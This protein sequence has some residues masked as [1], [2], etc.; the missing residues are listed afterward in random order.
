MHNFS[1]YAPTKV[2]FGRG[3][4]LQAGAVAKSFGAKKA[5]VHYGGGSAVR[6]GLLDRVKS[7][8]AEAGIGFVVLGG[9]VPNPQLS[10]VR[11]GIALCI[12]SGVDFVLAVGGGSVIDSAKAI[13]CGAAEPELDVWELF[14]KKRRARKTLPVG[15]VLTIAATGSEMSNSS[16][17]TNDIGEKRSY[18]DD[19]IRAK[20]A[21]MNPELTETLP[22][23]QT[24]AGCSDILL[25]T[26]ER[27]FNVGGTCELTDAIAAA[28]IKTVMKHAKIL[29]TDPTN[30]ESRAEVMWAGSLSHNDLTG[31]GG[32][33]RGDW[34]CHKL[35]HELSG[36]FGVTH[37]AGLT[38]LW[39]TW[40]RY[41]YAEC[42]DRFVKFALDV[43]GVEAGADDDE[44]INRGIAA[45]EDF[46]RS[47][48]M[49]TNLKELGVEPTEEQVLELARGCMKASG[50]P[51]GSIKPLVTEDMAAI[52]RLAR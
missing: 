11:E 21:I 10:K 52:Y 29:H 1:F 42:P 32:R 6:S 31:C 5:L 14:E 27:W 16:V 37:G 41:V 18:N 13:A 49:P 20:F 17:V 51:L 43:M 40:A 46:F 7:S 3:T 19:A 24:E 50:G 4:E 45:M 33:S 38:A 12:E 26:M 9:V 25:H 2:V 35:E 22:D 30:Y 44:T 36:M 23:Y 34:A 48:G 28:L 39:G 47:V 8:L 15:V